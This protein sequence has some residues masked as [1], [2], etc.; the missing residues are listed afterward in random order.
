[1][2]KVLKQECHFAEGQQ[3]RQEKLTSNETFQW[4]APCCFEGLQRCSDDQQQ[5]RLRCR[6]PRDTFNA[7]SDDDSSEGEQQ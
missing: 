7:L 2:G 6:G 1:M 5:R 3:S 4:T